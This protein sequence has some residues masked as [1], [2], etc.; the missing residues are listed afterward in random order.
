MG[1]IIGGIIGG[2]G[3]IFGGNS[4]AK[5]EQ[6]AAKTA[7]TGYNYLSSNPLI[8]QAQTNGSTALAGEANTTGDINQ[9][10]TSPSQNNPA[11][12]NYLNST[13]YNFQL[14][15]GSKAITSNAAAKGLLNSG[16][17]AKALTT[18]GQDLASTTFN[19]YLG[20]LGGL[21]GLQGQQANQGL[22]AAEAVG[23]AGTAGGAGAAQMTAQAGQSQGTSIAN[24]FNLFG[25]GLQST[26]NSGG[27]P[28]VFG[29]SAGSF[30]A[31]VGKSPNGNFL[32]FPGS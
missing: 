24:A 1:D 31:P 28:N 15:Q 22:G 30:G 13:G 17:T 4:A 9:L 14:D 18:Y 8:K 25:G 32:T 21:A 29:S 10:L 23:Q 11:F 19:N 26:I 6:A 20:Q 7:L 12:Q 3:S 27:L 5:Q 2:I 16:A